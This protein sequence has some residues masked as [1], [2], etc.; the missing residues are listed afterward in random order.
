MDNRGVTLIELL[1][2]L[3]ISAILGLVAIPA[4][5]ALIQ[6]QQLR[7]AANDVFRILTT[8]RATAITQQ[9]RISVWNQDGEW[10]R[11]VE[12]FIDSNGNGQRES[13]EIILSRPADH[14]SVHIS[15]NSKVA[16]YVSYLPN[17]RAERASGAFQVGTIRLCKTGI[18]EQYK[19]VI[20]IGG[21]LR[22]EKTNSASCP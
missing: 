4:F 17:G 10:N 9:N 1:A 6:Q 13:S 7:G 11:G 16:N 18:T 2:G 12:L 5:S 3:A 21:R 14:P 20:S 19:I 8:A 15:G 22:L